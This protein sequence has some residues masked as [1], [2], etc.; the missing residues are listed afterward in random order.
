VAATVKWCSDGVYRVSLKAVF[1]LRKLA[2]G[3][4]LSVSVLAT[5]AFAGALQ[6]APYAREV[7]GIDL[8]GAAGGWWDQA[9]GTYD[10]GQTPKVGA[11]LAFRATHSMR[12]GHVAMVQKVIDARHVLLNHANWSRP[13]MV[14]RNAMAEDVSAN[15]DWSQVRVWYAPIHDLGLRASPA[16]GFIYSNAPRGGELALADTGAA[17]N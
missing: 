4:A 6:C 13:G 7:S 15:G 2:A 5:P 9:A 1:G 12:S 8:H 14:E 10:R 17:A 16:Y 3:I 11:V